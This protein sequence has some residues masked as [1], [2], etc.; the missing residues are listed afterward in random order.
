MFHRMAGPSL[1]RGLPGGLKTLREF[2]RE[3]GGHLHCRNGA[4]HLAHEEIFDWIRTAVLR[5]TAFLAKRPYT[6]GAPVART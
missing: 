5:D 3:E 2:R 4:I 6:S 1:P